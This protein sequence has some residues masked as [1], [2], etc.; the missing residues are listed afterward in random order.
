VPAGHNA[1]PVHEHRWWG[2]LGRSGTAVEGHR[3]HEERRSWEHNG[4]DWGYP[5]VN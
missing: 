5:L 4:I 3:K 1:E 2:K